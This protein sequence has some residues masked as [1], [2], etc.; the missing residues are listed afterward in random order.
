MRHMF[1]GSISTENLM[2]T[3]VF[4]Y[5]QGRGVD[6]YTFGWAL[7][8]SSLSSPPNVALGYLNVDASQTFLK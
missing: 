4:T 8:P 5:V 3:L 2:V 1:Y 7:G 6:L